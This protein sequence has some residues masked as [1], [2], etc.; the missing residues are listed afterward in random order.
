MVTNKEYSIG[1]IG[2]D[3]IGPEVTDEAVRIL[4]RLSDH[5][6]FGINTE[7]Y[8]LGA[9]CLTRTGEAL[10]AS[11]VDDL[12][13]HDALLF[14]AVGTPAIA[15]GI[16]ER[17]LIL[18]LRRQFDQ[19]VNLRPV[20]LLSGAHA[21]LEQLH[22]S[23]DLVIVRENVEGLYAGAGG[24][25]YKGTSAEVATQE[26][27]NTRY[28]VERTVREAF[29][30]AESRRSKLALC[31]K[32]NVLEYSGSLWQRAV[33]DVA[34][35]FESVEVDYVHVDAMCAYLVTNPER[36]DVVVTDS[37]FGDIISDLGA[38]LVGGL[39]F[40][41]TGNINPSRSAPSMFEPIH[42]SA[43][44]I[45]GKGIANPISAILAMA[46]CLEHLGEAKAASLV[47]AG[48]QTYLVSI[49]SG[50]E[51][52]AGRTTTEIGDGILSSI[53]QGILTGSQC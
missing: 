33:D 46:M 3:G 19:F 52:V 35:E 28:G 25:A 22:K 48:I 36:F 1:V 18:E 6:D 32:V 11:V 42:G 17:G 53:E 38:A 40:A 37:M 2:G 23:C 41:G 9:R 51:T 30:L 15:P 47:N 5:F 45:A 50:G 44:D 14:G 16:L 27:V 8:D 20:R 31:H 24:V 13:Q 10:P 43:P 26:A 29:R 34:S 39:G 7:N 12:R 21:P 4:L 49:V